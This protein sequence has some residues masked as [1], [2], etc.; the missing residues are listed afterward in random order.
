MNFVLRFASRTWLNTQ[1]DIAL[2]FRRKR[3]ALALRRRALQLNPRDNVARSAV[4]NLLAQLGDADGAIDEFRRLVVFDERNADAWFNLGYLLEGRDALDEAER[5]FRRATEL[6]PKHD[7]AWYGLGLVLIRSD[8]LPEASGAL[9]KNTQLQPFS[10]YGW[11]QLA[12]THHHLGERAEAERIYHHLKTFEPRY[13]ATLKRDMEATPPRSTRAT[14]QSARV[15][16][17]E[18]STSTD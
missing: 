17:K 10:P 4:G 13:A 16:A 2:M 9:R 6:N 15:S 1:A 3:L 18:V 7:R 11:Y 8:R 14:A 5:A 12:M